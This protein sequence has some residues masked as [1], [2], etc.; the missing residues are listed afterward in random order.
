M[1]LCE[2][3]FNQMPMSVGH[4]PGAVHEQHGHLHVKAYVF[5]F[6]LK[7]NTFFFLTNYAGRVACYK[8]SYKVVINMKRY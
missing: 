4:E 2:R 8:K 7:K 6:Q 3:E 5:V 1:E